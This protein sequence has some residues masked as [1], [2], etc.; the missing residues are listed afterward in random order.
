MTD[1]IRVYEN[2]LSKEF[3]DN[4]ITVFEQSPH[5]KQG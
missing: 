5:L 1:F 2:A 4:F 3:C